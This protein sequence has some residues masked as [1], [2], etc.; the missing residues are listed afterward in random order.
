V[1]RVW[2]RL[3]RENRERVTLVLMHA[4]NAAL[5]YV[6]PHADI[7]V[8]S[9]LVAVAWFVQWRNRYSSPQFVVQCAVY[10]AC[11]AGALY[12]WWPR[13]GILSAVHVAELCAVLYT[14]RTGFLRTV[15]TQNGGPNGGGRRK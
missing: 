5:Q 1:L 8:G 15:G 11:V 10:E 13:I 9:R 6:W 7:E 3:R 4:G 14:F 2:F 12:V